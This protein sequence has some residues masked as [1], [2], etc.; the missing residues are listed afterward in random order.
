MSRRRVFYVVFFAL[1]VGAF[2]V[3]ISFVMP[4]YLHPKMPPISQVE[5]FAF[6]NQ[7]GQ[8]VTEK[9]LQGKVV[10]VNYFFTS[11]RSVCPRM[12]N[13]L[14]PV[15]EHF[16]NDPHFLIVSHTCDP[17][18]DSAA[19][20]KHYADSMGVDTRKWMFL[21]GRKDSLYQAARHI[22]KIDDPKN[23]VQNIKDDFLHTQFIALVDKKGAVVKIYDGIK[24]SEMKEMEAAITQLLKE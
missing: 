10:A 19:R 9:D 13:N 12:N 17:E 1:L 18:V 4:G 21:T 6:T 16:K 22:Y 5:P 23:Y 7:D 15:Y 3:A 11:C 24:P 20:L 14:K 8:A 2:F